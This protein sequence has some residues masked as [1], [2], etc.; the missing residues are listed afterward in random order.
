MEIENYLT[1][2]S[3]LVNLRLK[4]LF[5]NIFQFHKDYFDSHLNQLRNCNTLQA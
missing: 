3:Q 2:V 4:I 1:V 5:L